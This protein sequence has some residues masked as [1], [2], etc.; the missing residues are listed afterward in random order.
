LLHDF[1]MQQHAP[2]DFIVAQPAI[3]KRRGLRQG[4]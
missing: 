3:E 2:R 4:S 1:S